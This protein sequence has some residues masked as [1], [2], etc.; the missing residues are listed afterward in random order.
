MPLGASFFEDVPLVEFIIPGIY[1]HVRWSYHRRFRSLLLCPLSVKRYYFPWFVDYTQA[2][3]ASFCFR[4]KQFT[5]RSTCKCVY[6]CV[7]MLS[8]F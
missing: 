1:L 3:K 5:P 6:V 7:Y 8:Q 2:L 4:L